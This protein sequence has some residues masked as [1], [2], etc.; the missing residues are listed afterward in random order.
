MPKNV[1]KMLKYDKKIHNSYK[2]HNFG[3]KI[4]I[5]NNF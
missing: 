5:M 2:N 1:I 4:F 3:A